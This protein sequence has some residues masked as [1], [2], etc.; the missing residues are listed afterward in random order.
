MKVG[1]FC[2]NIRKID[3]FFEIFDFFLVFNYLNVHN[4][5]EFLKFFLSL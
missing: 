3:F 5:L 1:R 2:Q 4:I